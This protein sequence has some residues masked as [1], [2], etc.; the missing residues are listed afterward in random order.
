MLYYVIQE[1]PVEQFRLMV[2]QMIRDD[3]FSVSTTLLHVC[4][5]RKQ[6][7]TIFDP[8]LPTS[9]VQFS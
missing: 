6:K 8:Q 2:Q 9:T 7:R 1:D 5:Q 3:Y 4:V